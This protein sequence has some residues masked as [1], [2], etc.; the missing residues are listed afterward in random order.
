MRELGLGPGPE[1][2]RILG[3]LL[4]EVLEDPSLNARERLLTRIRTGFS[5]DTPGPGT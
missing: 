2:G 4:E 5:I 3:R 1:V